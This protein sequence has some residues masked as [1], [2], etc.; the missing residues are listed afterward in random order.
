LP[1]GLLQISDRASTKRYRCGRFRVGATFPGSS[2]YLK[3]PLWIPWLAKSAI[4]SL[5]S[6]VF[7]HAAARKLHTYAQMAGYRGR[8][9]I[10]KKYV[11][12]L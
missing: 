12:D 6:A 4:V 2:F 5:H 9:R 7:A 10:V 3:L 11:T 1:L 8:Y